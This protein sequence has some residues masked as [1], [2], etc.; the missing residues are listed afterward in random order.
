MTNSS[1]S[2]TRVPSAVSTWPPRSS[3]MRWKFKDDACPPSRFGIPR[4]LEPALLLNVGAPASPP[5]LRALTLSLPD[6][7]VFDCRATIR[8]LPFMFLSRVPLRSRLSFPLSG[9][10]NG[11]ALAVALFFELRVVPVSLGFSA[12]EATVSVCTQKGIWP[13][14]LCTLLVKSLLLKLGHCPAGKLGALVI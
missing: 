11:V 9:L 1:I 14:E 7:W 6:D 13:Y 12:M 10:A 8:S 4:S 3:D 2:A 5:G